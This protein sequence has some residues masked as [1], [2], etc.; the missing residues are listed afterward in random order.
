MRV[1]G[2]KA[3]PKEIADQ[4]ID[5]TD[6]VP[7]F[8]EEL[9]KSVIES[10]LVR[11]AGH[12]F[13]LA[14]VAAPLAIPTSLNA[15]L[16]AR[17]DRLAPR[18]IAQIGAALGR[19]FSHELISGVA[20]MPQH[21]LDI[22]LE[23]LTD[24]GLI[25]RSGIPPHA[26]YTFKHALVQDAGYGTLLR[27]RRQQLHACIA[28]TLEDQ[29]PQIVA[30][31]PALLAHHCEEAGLIEKAVTYWLTA[32]RQAWRLATNMEAVA[33]L[34]RGLTLIPRLPENGWR[35]E[36]EA[37]LQIALL[38]N[39]FIFHFV[40]GELDEAED[41]ALEFLALGKTRNDINWRLAGLFLSG[42][43]SSVLGK[44]N[45]ARSCCE[46]A[47]S[48]WDPSFRDFVPSREDLYVAARNYLYRA[49]LCLGYVDQ[50]RARRSKAWLTH[51]R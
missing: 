51:A 46:T 7:L 4:I 13:A 8:I 29:F 12:H 41:D 45:D 15:S 47:I 10:G 42:V 21:E 31:Q 5:R 27:T 20:H 32:G 43:L 36:R 11:E 40:G 33:L 25:L 19:S 2:G 22:A 39:Q 28:A 3:L 44:F 23:Q 14:G 50:A 18:E 38:Y 9:T 35:Q 17:L 6:G 16:L 34:R 1:T 49:L 48:I 26:V 37:E 24:A 30:A